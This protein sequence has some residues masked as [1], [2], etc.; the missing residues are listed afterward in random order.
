ML[1]VLC[2]LTCISRGQASDAPTGAP[3]TPPSTAPARKVK[4]NVPSF[5]TPRTRAQHAGRGAEGKVLPKIDVLLPDHLAGTLRERPV[6]FWFISESTDLPCELKFSDDQVKDQLWTR[7]QRVTQPGIM[8]V[9]WPD[10]A[11]LKPDRKFIW[12]AILIVDA[13][14]TDKNPQAS[15]KLMRVA[16]PPGLEQNLASATTPVQRFEILADAGLFCD[17]LAEIS[18]AIDANPNNREL[19]LL[20]ADFLDQ[21][22]LTEAA[23]FERNALKN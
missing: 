19:R 20:R 16:A 10:D 7:S 14:D 23:E 5:G 9:A 11:G 18:D 13:V 3:T 21:A 2:M 4:Y 17:A 6:L 12:G 22:G 15:G 8:S 1:G